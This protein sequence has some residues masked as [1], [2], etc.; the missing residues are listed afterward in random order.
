M[1][2]YPPGDH[3]DRIQ[4][5]LNESK[6]N[7]LKDRYGMIFDRVSEDVPPHMEA[8]FLS[9]IEEIE[10][11]GEHRRTITVREFLG[12]PDVRPFDEIP[13][14][15]LAGELERLM[16]IMREYG[17][18]LDFICPVS[19]DIAYR[20]IVDELLDQEMDDIRIEGMTHAFLYEEFHPNHFY[21]I[22]TI[23]LD[24]AEGLIQGC[25]WKVDLY[26]T[27]ELRIGEVENVAI[28][29]ARLRLVSPMLGGAVVTS[30]SGAVGPCRVDGE[31]GRAEVEVRWKGMMIDSGEAREGRFRWR[32][33]MELRH[34]ELWVVAAVTPIV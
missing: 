10:R 21:D 33:D 2:Q 24:V 29:D 31:K 8:E 15:K 25:S 14:D 27:N 4:R 23:A 19:N 16:S 28:D 11:Q 22:S 30:V 13:S 1:E 9:Y 34:G 7:A 12:D 5:A 3:H 26:C 17:V 18:R 20:F 6:R 32:I